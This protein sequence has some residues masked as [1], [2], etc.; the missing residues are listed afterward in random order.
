M[1]NAT[2]PTIARWQLGEELANLRRELGLA[3]DEVA[4]HLGCSEAKIRRIEKG[5]VGVVQAEL[6][7]LLELFKVNDADH[8]EHLMSLQKLGK[9]RGWWSKLGGVPAPYAEFLGIES[10]ATILRIFEPQLIH[11]LLQ[12][13]AYTRALLGGASVNATPTAIDQQVQI[14]KA[15]QERILG[16]EEPPTLWVVLDEAAILR[17]IGS[18]RIMQDQIAH[19]IDLA[20]RCTLQVVELGYGA[21]PG[22]FGAFTIFEF[23]EN[24]HSPVVYVEGQAGNLYLEKSDDLSK[25][26]LAFDHLTA[27]ALS[28]P[29]SVRLLEKA[30]RQFDSL[31][32]GQ[33]A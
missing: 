25:C 11:G 31:S 4:A 15:R 32:G 23:D 16:A 33:Q 3:W 28:P 12:T 9:Q 30:A 27:A 18:P 24:R 29:D 5:E 14:R 10:S 1:P 13:E 8:R 7:S 19:L 26:K 2:G 22:L 17:P 21:H 20:H 6:K